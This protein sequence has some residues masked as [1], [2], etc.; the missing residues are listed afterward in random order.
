ME[1]QSYI[2]YRAT[3]LGSAEGDLRNIRRG[4]ESRATRD[5]VSSRFVETTQDRSKKKLILQRVVTKIRYPEHR[6]SRSSRLYCTGIGFGSSGIISTPGFVKFDRLFEKPRRRQVGVLV[7]AL[8]WI[9][10]GVLISGL[11]MMRLDVAGLKQ[12]HIPVLDPLYVTEVRTIDGDLDM[13]AQNVTVEGMRNI[14]I[15]SVR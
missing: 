1:E 4:G 7:R 2:T 12:Y 14:I 11:V 13:A 10:I 15:K 9:G 3:Q 6:G 5:V 8:A